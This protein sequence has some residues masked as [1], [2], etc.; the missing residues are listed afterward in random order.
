MSTTDFRQSRRDAET[1]RR[2]QDREDRRQAQEAQLQR[3]Q[4]VLT[5]NLQ[6][7]RLQ[8]EAD[9]A[10]REQ[11]RADRAA[12]AER[13]RLAQEIKDRQRAERVERERQVAAAAAKEKARLKAKAKAE[14]RERRNAAVKAAPGFVSQHLDL[15]AALVVMACSIIP[16]LISQS[17]SLSDTGITA[18]TA[19]GWQGSLLVALLPV[20]LECSAWAATAGEAK[21]L[22][23][24]RSPWA[25][26]IAVYLFAGLAAWVNWQHGNNAGG[27]KYGLLLG[28]VLAASSVIPI[29]VWQLVQVGRHREVKAKLKAERLARREDRRTTRDRKRL[30][31]DV[32]HT[33]QQLRAI[34]G[35]RRLSMDEAWQGAYAVHEG[36]GPEA[37]PADLMV[38]LSAELLGLRAEAEKGLADVLGKLNEARALRLK[39]S[40]SAKENTSVQATENVHKASPNASSGRDTIPPTHPGNRSLHRAAQ[41]ARKTV[42]PQD[43]PSVPLSAPAREDKPARTRKPR[44]PRPERTLSEGAKKAARQTALASATDA[45]AAEKKTLE[46]WAADELRADRKVTWHAVQAETLRR[47]KENDKKAVQPSRSWSYD[48]LTAAKKRDGGDGSLHIVRSA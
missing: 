6:R 10:A 45:A 46:D 11:D 33:A 42:S 23:Q 25:Y 48:R 47:R 12:A 36:A 34:A 24:G 1:S 17:A 35:H 9:T 28:S 32:W 5:A 16:A 4:L 18:P 19:M 14:R 29:A 31:A 20:M 8:A 21:A 3:E 27:D 44:P 37:L 15:V 39:V 41:R 2:E 30:Y 7:A 13:E 38:L 26:R 43:A 40:G 22:A